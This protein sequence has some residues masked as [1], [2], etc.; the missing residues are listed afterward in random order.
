M[1]FLAADIQGPGMDSP[2][3]I[4]VWA[5]SAIEGAGIAPA[6]WADGYAQNFSTWG[7]ARKDR[8]F[9]PNTDGI[10][11]SKACVEHLLR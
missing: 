11:E 1:W 6:M 5:V 7:T 4:G 2:N 10:A 9:S 3:E 8:W